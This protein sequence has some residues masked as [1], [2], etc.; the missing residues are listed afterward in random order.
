MTRKAYSTICLSIETCEKVDALARILSCSKSG[1]IERVLSP[2][3]E[4][5]SV[6]TTAELETYPFL[7]RGNVVYQ[8]FG[9][10]TNGKDNRVKVVNDD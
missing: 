5:S 2:L 1:L 9:K 7:T 10:H 8:L 4:V 3:Y 6:Y